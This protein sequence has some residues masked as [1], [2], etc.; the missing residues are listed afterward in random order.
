MSTCEDF[1]IDIV[2]ASSASPDEPLRPAFTAHLAHCSI[3]RKELHATRDTVNLLMR[4]REEP[5]TLT[6]AG[7]AHRTALAAESQSRPSFQSIRKRFNAFVQT[8]I[9]VA[10]GAL[11]VALAV[12]VTPAPE[13]P[14]TT[15]TVRLE[16]IATIEELSLWN[17]YA[18]GDVTSNGDASIQD[19]NF[20]LDDGL[21]ELD[22]VEL[23]HLVKLLGENS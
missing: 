20:T 4:T 3:C 12:I 14:S 6:L 17:M 5:D 11:A 21:A 1:I 18:M 8:A 7:F 22:D 2:D 10:G 23:A 13:L 9:L 19:S 15:P 16:E